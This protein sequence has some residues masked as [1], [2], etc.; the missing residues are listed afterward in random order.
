MVYAHQGSSSDNAFTVYNGQP[1]RTF[2]AFD[3]PTARKKYQAKVW[4]E[5]G[6]DEN[7]IFCYRK[8][9]EEYKGRDLYYHKIEDGVYEVWDEYQATMASY[10]QLDFDN[11]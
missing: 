3:T 9:V 2:L 1:T 8:D 10:N 5:S 11:V 6:Q 4:S 7:V